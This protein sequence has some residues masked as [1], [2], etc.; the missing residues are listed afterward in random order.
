M[1][2]KKYLYV[3]LIFRIFTE[4]LFLKIIIKIQKC[5][6][7]Y[8]FRKLNTNNMVFKQAFFTHSFIKLEL[9]FQVYKKIN[10]IFSNF[11]LKKI[12]ANIYDGYTRW[13]R[14][15]IENFW[16][17]AYASYTQMRNLFFYVDF[18]ILDFIKCLVF[19]P[20]LAKILISV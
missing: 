18:M 8:T 17:T 14:Y 4:E 12:K 19:W 20:G 2:D 13:K 6:P 10:W 1:A 9:I 11:L 15:Q 7:L 3:K 5:I 16:D